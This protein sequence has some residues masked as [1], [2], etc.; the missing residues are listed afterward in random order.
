MPLGWTLDTVDNRMEIPKRYN[1]A[2]EKSF[3]NNGRKVAFVGLHLWRSDFGSILI[4]QWRPTPNL[5]A[6]NQDCYS[7]FHFS[8]YGLAL[9]IF[10]AVGRLL[11]PLQCSSSKW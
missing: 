1:F 3:D 9:C 6:S 4:P 5:S 2:M 7:E 11:S 8:S 10:S